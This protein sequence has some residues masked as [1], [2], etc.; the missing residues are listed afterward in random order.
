L[1]QKSRQST[2]SSQK[3]PSPIVPDEWIKDF[4][5]DKNLPLDMTEALAEFVEAGQWTFNQ[6]VVGIKEFLESPHFMDAKGVIWPEVMIEL[7]EINSGKYTELLAT[8]GIGS[9]KSTIALYSI[10]YQLYLLSCIHDPHKLYDLDPASEIVFVFQNIKETLAKSVD[11]DR[12]RSMCEKSPY[13]RN[14]FGFD[15]DFKSEMHFPN[16]IIVKPV[17]GEAT[18][19]IGQNVVGGI[20]DEVNHMAV[21]EKSRRAKSGDSTYDQAVANYSSLARRRKT[22]F[23]RAGGRMPG[24]LCMVGSRL[25]NGDF[26]DRKEAEAKKEKEEKGKSS[27]YVYDRRVWEVCPKGWY[28]DVTFKLFVGDE[29][30]Q[31]RLVKPGARLSERDKKLIL[32]IPL[33]FKSEFDRDI[34]NA[35]REVAGHS[36]QAVHPFMQDIVRIERCFGKVKSIF[37]QEVVDFAEL[38]LTIRRRRISHFSEP[39]AAHIDLGVTSDSCGIT[40]CH[41]VKF[42]P[43]RRGPGIIEMLPL[44]QIDG[45]L[46][47]RPP[48]GGEIMFD[49]I[50][51]IF[52]TLRDV[53]GMPIRWISFDQF[54]STDSRQ[55]LRQK[56]FTTGLVSMDRTT[57]PYDLCKTTL[58]DH[59]VIA[60]PHAKCLM[61]LK[62]LERDLKKGKIDHRPGLSK[63]VSDSLAGALY[64][65]TMRR[66]VWLQH[67][68]TPI[69]VPLSIQ[70]AASKVRMDKQQPWEEREDD[71]DPARDRM[72]HRQK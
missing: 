12:F 54:Q 8:G 47:I 15:P 52:L 11:Y 58:Y 35:T 20:L 64:T 66:E 44:I 25:Y 5:E 60:P 6:R 72:Y 61:E 2:R 51:S 48:A 16:R 14:H 1:K 59:R 18:A 69:E 3:P 45:Q 40:I 50:R 57:A 17:T 27:I 65:L 71:G 26:T 23:M 9:A 46:E 34:M 63:D 21:V 62:G 37:M 42:V 13:F 53:I 24:L 36:T 70:E 68:I 10:A 67:G 7:E 49:K 22:R 56:G 41:V 39:R 55:I 30:R 33:E 43:V 32:L 28:G 31:P 19:A 38:K 4:L 29:T